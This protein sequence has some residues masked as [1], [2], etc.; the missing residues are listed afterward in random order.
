MEW[1]DK[2]AGFVSYGG[3]GAPRTVEHGRG[4]MEELKLAD[5]RAQVTLSLH[6]DF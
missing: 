2:A 6:T 1:N 4:V 5:V 3:A